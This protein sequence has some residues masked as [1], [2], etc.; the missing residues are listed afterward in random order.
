MRLGFVTSRG[1]RGG[2]ASELELADVEQACE[3][4]LN[5]WEC[6]AVLGVAPSSPA[7][8]RERE[9]LV[10]TRAPGTRLEGRGC[11]PRWLSVTAREVALHAENLLEASY[12]SADPQK[13]ADGVRRALDS[14]ASDPPDGSA[15]KEAGNS[16][17]LDVLVAAVAVSVLWGEQEQESEKLSRRLDRLERSLT[18]LGGGEAPLAA[19][20]RLARAALRSVT[21][22]VDGVVALASRLVDHHLLALRQDCLGRALPALERFSKH[23]AASYTSPPA[24]ALAA[25]LVVELMDGDVDWTSPSDVGGLSVADLAC[26]TGTLLKAFVEAA[27]DRH[28]RE[29]VAAGRRPRC[30]LAR[31]FL[32]EDGAWGVDVDQAAV[33]LAA[34]TLGLPP[35]PAELGKPPVVPTRCRVSV[36]PVGTSPGGASLGGLEVLRR[37]VVAS[38]VDCVVMNPPFSRAVRGNLMFG[39]RGDRATR[40]MVAAEL[41]RLVRTNRLEASLTAGLASAFAAAGHRLVRPG[42]ALALVLPAASLSGASWAPTRRLFQRYRRA[43]VLASHDPGRP[44]FSDRSQLAEVLVVL[45]G[46]RGEERGAAGGVVEVMFCNLRR[47]PE[48][49]PEAWVVLQ[50]LVPRASSWPRGGD[51]RAASQSTP[52]STMVEA[53][54]GLVGSLVNA[55]LEG[56]AGAGEFRWQLPASFLQAELVDAALRLSRGKFPSRGTSDVPVEFPTSPLGELLVLGPD[57]RDVYDAFEPTNDPEGPGWDSPYEALWGMDSEAARTPLLVP[58]ARLVPLKAPRKGRRLRRPEDLWAMAG[59][60]V[61]PK[62]LRT[63]TCA[64]SVAMLERPALSNV[65][66]PARWA[67]GR[68]SGEEAGLEALACWLLSTPGAVVLLAHRQATSGAWA[69]FTKA[70]YYHLP[71]L[72]VRSLAAPQMEVLGAAWSEARGRRFQPFPLAST[73]P[74]RRQLDEALCEALGFDLDVVESLRALLVDEPCVNGVRSVRK[75]R[76]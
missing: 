65:W 62:E 45:L 57:G 36:V 43:I 25:G 52:Q 71:V 28:W 68:P 10:L 5:S 3:A 18:G 61:L 54:D 4:L 29:S 49:L 12:Q 32:V 30:A 23:R 17:L 11:A 40:R 51:P 15:Q 37:P 42:G 31:K 7:K 46:K 14:G 55:R 26:G 48:T 16:G 8:E 73:D 24:A 58:N 1:G 2:G 41:G 74:A 47:R 39:D 75:R 9:V 56:D 50:A 33:N 53:G 22:G 13:V 27:V 34:A 69:K 64:L 66:W 63:N 21:N 72:D 76:P 70:N 59:R 20:L 6:D 44:A 35:R 19:C 67:G 38:P 60:L